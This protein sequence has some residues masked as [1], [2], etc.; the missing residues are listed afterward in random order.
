[1]ERERLIL[2]SGLKIISIW[3]LDFDIQFNKKRRSSLKK[4]NTKSNFE[5]R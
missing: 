1:M 4:I 5:V 2:N 3:E